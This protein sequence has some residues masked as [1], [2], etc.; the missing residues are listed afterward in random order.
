MPRT[1]FRDVITNPELVKS[2]NLESK[3]LVD[4]FLRYKGM[5]SGGLT[6]AGY[7]SDLQ[8]FLC[9]NVEHNDNKR[10]TDIRKID[11]SEFFSFGVEELKWSFSR[12]SRM[13]YALSSFCNF[14]ERFYDDVYPNFRNP[15]LRA[16]ES[17]PKNIVREKTV[18]TEEQVVNVFNCL[19]G[20]KY[21]QIACWFALAISSGARFSELLRF[22]I[23]NISEDNTAFD[24]MFLETLHPIKTKGRTRDG[25]PL[26]KYIIKDIFVKYYRLWLPE[27][28]RLMV[29]MGKSHDF[30]FVRSNGDPASESVV[31][32]WVDKIES[33]LDVPF[34]P[35][36]CRHYCASYLAKV[37]LPYALIQEILGWES[38]NMVEVYNDAK[39]KDRAWP[40]LANLK[41]ALILDFTG[42]KNNV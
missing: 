35:H 19:I 24:G 15:V 7:R 21:Y 28:Q 36:C 34:Y 6:I 4:K 38:A 5:S 27:R 3:T 25:K 20:A 30:I 17:L 37:G 31:R 2:I 23:D 32:G 12:F 11:F 29:G 22:T 13:K 26:V 39:I 42:R 41:E 1:T 8:I 18:L 14:I 33:Y 10:F 16:V 9:W 40:E